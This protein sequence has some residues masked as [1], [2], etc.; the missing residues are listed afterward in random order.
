MTGGRM[1]IKF[2]GE[3]RRIQDNSTFSFLVRP[4][5]QYASAGGLTMFQPGAP[6]SFFTQNLYLT[7]NTSLRG[8]RMTEWAPY[9]Q[10]TTRVTRNLTLELGLRYEYLGRASEVNGFLSNAFLAPNGTPLA[11]T[12]LIANG[13][14]AL[15]QVRLIPIG[16][17][18]QLG[19]FQAD[20]NNWAPRIGAAWTLGSTTIR[21]S[22]G[23]YYD[24]I[25]DNVLGNARN[26]PPYVVVVT[27]GGIPF[28]TS[29]SDPNP[30]TTDVPI[31]PT[32]VNP[33]LRFP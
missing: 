22:Y 21:G 24:R 4:N 33:D 6:M 23:I 29:V 3:I 32:T 11:G 5:A 12:S 17:G 7:P 18:R 14:A 15:N 19:L 30:F 31:G 25:F 13:I 26:S 2:G 1:S 9:I 8:F 27:T 28:G 16:K 10:T 20:T